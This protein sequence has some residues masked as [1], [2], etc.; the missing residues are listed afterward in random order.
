MRGHELLLRKIL[1]DR[2]PSVA[3]LCRNPNVG[4]RGPLGED[5]ATTRFYR[6]G[7]RCCGVAPGCTGTTV[8]NAGDRVARQYDGPTSTVLSRIRRRA[9][10]NGLRPRTERC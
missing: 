2:I 3:N 1:I 8:D 10:G 4:R 5:N 9:E 6:A 7:W